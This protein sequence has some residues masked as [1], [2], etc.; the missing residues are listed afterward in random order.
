MDTYA[1]NA[2]VTNVVTE[3]P[4]GYVPIVDIPV[5]NAAVNLLFL[6]Q[7]QLLSPT[8]G[9]NIEVINP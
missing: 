2:P 1:V 9:R 6:F 3:I 7:V 4:A 8:T 5:V